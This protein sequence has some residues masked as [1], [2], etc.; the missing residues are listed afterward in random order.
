ML[1]QAA[2][3]HSCCN[4]AYSTIGIRICL[5]LTWEADAVAM[6]VFLLENRADVNAVTRSGQTPLDRLK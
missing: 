1:L 4:T 5:S 6:M 2:S 3:M